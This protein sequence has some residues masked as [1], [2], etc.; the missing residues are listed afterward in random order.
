MENASYIL[1]KKLSIQDLFFSLLFVSLCGFS[2]GNLIPGRTY[3]LFYLGLFVLVKRIKRVDHGFYPLKLFIAF[4]IIAFAHHYLIIRK[5]DSNLLIC[6][7]QFLAAWGFF[8]YMGQRANY[9]IFK[10]MVALSFFSLLCYGI[11]VIAGHAPHVDFLNAAG[12]NYRGVFLWNSRLDEIYM[13]RNCGPFWE[14]GAFAGYIIM[15]FLLYFRELK[16]LWVQ[17]KISCCILGLALIT[18]FSSQGYLAFFALAIIKIFLTTNKKNVSLICVCLMFACVVISVLF[19][20]V[21]FLGKKLNKQIEL[22]KNYTDVVSVE[23]STRFTTMMIDFDNIATSPFFG[24]TGE[25]AYLYQ[26]FPAVMKIVERKG[27]YGTGTGMTGFIAS[28]GIVLWLVWVMLSYRSLRYKYQRKKDAVMILLALILLG[29][30]E[31]YLSRIFYLSIPFWYLANNVIYK[32]KEYPK[33]L[34]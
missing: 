27:Y 9:A 7:Q 25:T 12:S 14:P 10:V 29:Q 26:N 23:S 18:T 8:L 33:T 5:I 20:N 32:N 4:L 31:Q 16:L 34:L 2:S 1:K 22:S 28:H 11:V 21:Q 6:L 17:E 13:R 30:G 19:F 24:R 3:I 15:T